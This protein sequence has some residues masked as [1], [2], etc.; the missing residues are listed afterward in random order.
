MPGWLSVK[1]GEPTAGV[2]QCQVGCSEVGSPLV[3]PVAPPGA[4]AWLASLAAVP[5]FFCRVHE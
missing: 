1:V 3:C 4:P 2:T 5:I